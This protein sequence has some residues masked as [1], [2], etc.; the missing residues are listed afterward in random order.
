MSEDPGQGPRHSHSFD[1]LARG[2]A[3]G[4]LSRRRALKIFAAAVVGALVPTP[5]LAVPGPCP[6]NSDKVTICHRPPGNPSNA[7]TLCVGAPA[8]E[9]HF[10]EHELDTPGACPPPSPPPPPGPPPPPEPC[11]ERGERCGGDRPECCGNLECK[12]N[13]YGEDKRC[14]RRR[15]DD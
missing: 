3:S 13:A 15:D 1:E 8:A 4:G 9:R 12:G 10:A 6:P 11:R 5:A 7:Q 14:R 2:L